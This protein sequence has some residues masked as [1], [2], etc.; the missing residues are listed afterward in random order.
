[1]LFFSLVTI[2]LLIYQISEI[3]TIYANLNKDHSSIC[4][5]YK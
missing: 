5:T 4:P 2:L 1:M 3:L